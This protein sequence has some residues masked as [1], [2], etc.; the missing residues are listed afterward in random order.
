MVEVKSS[1]SILACKLNDG[2]WNFHFQNSQSLDITWFDMEVNQVDIK[3]HF[4]AVTEL[5]EGVFS[6]KNQNKYLNQ[7]Y[8]QY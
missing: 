2:L 8:L 1:F 4:E 5:P 7:T 3:D 6:T